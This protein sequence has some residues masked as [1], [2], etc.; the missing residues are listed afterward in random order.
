MFTALNKNT[1]SSTFRGAAWAQH[2]NVHGLYKGEVDNKACLR[3]HS[4]PFP[5]PPWCNL[6]SSQWSSWNTPQVF[7]ISNTTA[8][9]PRTFRC[10]W[11]HRMCSNLVL[12]QQHIFAFTHLNI[13]KTYHKVF[14]IGQLKLPGYGWRRV[15]GLRR[16]VFAPHFQSLV[17]SDISS[18]SLQKSFGHAA[19]I[20]F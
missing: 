5:K 13:Q 20:T 10:L 14:S 17:D 11:V 2:N 12:L 16:W 18:F 15:S 4:N 7:I 9:I 6:S 19:V 1:G 3:A 8:V